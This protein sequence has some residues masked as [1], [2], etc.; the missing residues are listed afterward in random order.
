ME[1]MNFMDK[2]L[3]ISMKT[4]LAAAAAFLLAGC[5]D[6][7][8][9]T[10][11]RFTASMEL[12]VSSNEVIL[13]EGR[14]DDVA[15]VVSWTAATDYGKDF[16]TE[17][18]YRMNL[19][20]ST[21][22]AR[23]EYEDMGIFRRE[24][25]NREL[26]ELMVDYFKFKTSS[27]GTMQFRVTAEFEGDYLVVPEQCDVEV[28]VKTYGEKQFAADRFFLSGTAAGSQDI[29]V[30]PSS[31]SPSVY[32]WTGS[33]SA[34]K[35]NFHIVYGD[36]DNVI[37]PAGGSDAA[38]VE[39][40]MDAALLDW[41]ESAPA[42][43]I[44][45]SEPYRITVNMDTRTVGIIPVSSIIEIDRL[46]MA[47]TSLPG[48]VELA[49]TLENDAVYAWKGLLNAGT[50]NFPV[51]FEGSRGTM[52]VPSRDGQG[53][54][55]GT[56]DAFKAAT[57][58]SSLYWEIPADGTYR[59]V[60]DTDARNVTIYSEATDI[61]CKTVTFKRTAGVADDNCTVEIT[62]LWIYSND[63]YMTGSKPI[64]EP[65]VLEQ[66]LADPRLFVYRGAELK[67]NEPVK[68]CVTD[69]WNNEYAFGAGSTGSSGNNVSVAVTPGEKTQPLYGGQGN[70][71]YTFFVIPSGTNYIELYV[72][73]E[74]SDES[75]NALSQVYAIEGSY[76]LFDKR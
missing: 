49:R 47:G 30:E 38:I 6:V 67:A 39:D 19:Y 70:N 29:E 76:V 35:L 28:R 62:R 64:G 7:I 17:Y 33:L 58:G 68:F 74:S 18:Q 16:I 60:V 21:V 73:P 36:E 61:S 51:E 14:P 59:V 34:G 66:S 54:L 56:A 63:T 41:S 24:Y 27:W 65:F 45:S 8:D 43:I 3:S 23:N 20:E 50:L 53:F 55:D 31:S 72:G 44:P 40:P 13:D 25:T 5:E 10:Y 9:N 4:V 75:G 12:T 71:R 26:Q 37:V 42:W 15:L 46:Y 1:R 32:I 11:S 57:Y 2:I 48:E 69:N 22:A 52:L